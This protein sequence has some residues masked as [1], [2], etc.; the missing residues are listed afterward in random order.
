MTDDDRTHRE[1]YAG[2]IREARGAGDDRFHAWFN[3]AV[4]EEEAMRRGYWDFALHILTPPVCQRIA[5]PAALTALEIGYGGGRLVNAAASYFGRVVGIDV[6]DELDQ[7]AA[8]LE[9]RGHTNVTL[10]KTDGS[11][12]GVDDGSVDLVYSFIV[13]QHLPRYEAFVRYLEETHRVLADGGVAQLYYGRLKS[14]DPRRRYR[15]IDAPV[16]QISLQ[17]APRHVHR[18][19]RRIGF[20]VLARGHS[21]KNVPD[22]YPRVPG[23]QA[24]VTLVKL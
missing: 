18:L 22:G 3:D 9:R 24:A 11:S 21:Y 8:L 6:H 4:S 13:L 5:E 2:A 12:I 14:R 10:L 17:V 15:E 1:R 23:G 7:V 16:N 20:D 19:C